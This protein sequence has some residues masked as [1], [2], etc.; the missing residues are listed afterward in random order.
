LIIGKRADQYI[1]GPKLILF[2]VL[3]G[4]F[5]APFVEACACVIFGEDLQIS[6][7][8]RECPPPKN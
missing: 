4:L 7:P 5:V 6:G 8:P 2:L 3:V 1:N